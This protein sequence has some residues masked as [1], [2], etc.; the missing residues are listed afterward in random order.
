MAMVWPTSPAATYLGIS[1]PALRLQVDEGLAVWR[2]AILA[3]QEAHQQVESGRKKGYLT[4][5]QVYERPSTVTGGDSN[6]G[7]TGR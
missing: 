2:Q 7:S 6:D 5:G 3:E 4:R 1:D